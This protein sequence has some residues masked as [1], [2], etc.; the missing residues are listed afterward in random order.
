MWC[1]AMLIVIDYASKGTA[2]PFSIDHPKTTIT[3]VKPNSPLI[4]ELPWAGKEKV[5]TNH[6]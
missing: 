2:W 4:V 1:T 5:L 3:N 6:I